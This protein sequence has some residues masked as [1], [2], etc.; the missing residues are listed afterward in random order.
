MTETTLSLLQIFSHAARVVFAYAV[1][2]LLA[3]LMMSNWALPYF[4]MIKP[5]LVL[6]VVFYWTLYRPTLMPPVVILLV[7]LLFDLMN[8][9]MPVGTHAAS[10]LLVAGIL[11]PRRRSLMG[12]PFVVI[13]AGFAVAVLIDLLFKWFALSILSPAD[14]T[15]TMILFNGF[16]TMLSFPLVVMVLTLVHRLLPAGRG[17]ITR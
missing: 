1:F 8:P 11:K 9:V 15:F 13:W 4:S 17:M 12:Q 7:G 6:V 5:Q 10:Y 3:L 2:I 16:I 14:L